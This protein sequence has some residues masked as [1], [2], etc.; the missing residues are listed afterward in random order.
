MK[1]LLDLSPLVRDPDRASNV[2]ALVLRD[3]ATAV[4]E[5]GLPLSL[6]A[7]GAAPAADG[8]GESLGCRWIVAP[9][10]TADADDDALHARLADLRE[11]LSEAPESVLDVFD[12]LCDEARKLEAYASTFDRPRAGES[13]LR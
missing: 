1:L 13:P 8:H 3:L 6:A 9:E 11:F 12:E 4:A 7:P 5:S 2:V 10:R